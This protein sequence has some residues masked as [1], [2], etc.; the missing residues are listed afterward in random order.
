[1]ENPIKMDDL[2]VPLFLIWVVISLK[3]KVVGSHGV[4]CSHHQTQGTRFTSSWIRAHERWNTIPSDQVTGTELT[5][6][7]T[8]S[9]H[10]KMDGWNSSFLY[11]IWPD[12]EN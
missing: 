10:L 11:A 4:S 8:N 6:P 2:G 5:I 3:M 12:L 7:E 1:M 9:L